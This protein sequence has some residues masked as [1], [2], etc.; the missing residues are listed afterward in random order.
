MLKSRRLL[1]GSLVAL[2]LTVPLGLAAW[3]LIDER[4]AYRLPGGTVIRFNSFGYGQARA[5]VFGPTSMRRLMPVAHLIPP[6]IGSRINWE[7]YD[8]G[9]FVPRDALAIG[10]VHAGAPNPAMPSGEIVDRHGCRFRPMD[11]YSEQATGE[12]ANLSIYPFFPRRE[13]SFQLEMTLWPPAG[14]Q[15]VGSIPVRNPVGTHYP[16]WTASPLPQTQ[17][18]GPLAVTLLDASR[19][20]TRLDAGRPENEK[21]TDLVRLPYRLDGSQGGGAE[22]RPVSVRL[23]DAMGGTCRIDWGAWRR[24][25]GAILVRGDNLC[26]E[27]PAYEYRLEFSRAQTPGAEPDQLLELGNM[28]VQEGVHTNF[29]LP[30]GRVVNVNATEADDSMLLFGAWSPQEGEIGRLLVGDSRVQAPDFE[31]PMM[32]GGKPT[33]SQQLQAKVRR[34]TK[35]AHLHFGIYRS[36]FVTFR[37]KPRWLPPAPAPE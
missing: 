26:R 28:T 25:R 11:N 37:I 24:T 19:G 31:V 12:S 35:L 13:E 6:A 18:S 5:Q 15:R 8:Y 21:Q 4:P 30:D 1:T 14:G 23:S 33:L 34:G 7:G 27:E 9:S 16:T 29:S 20:W 32:P 22:W 36:R 3:L 2:A 10:L 17:R